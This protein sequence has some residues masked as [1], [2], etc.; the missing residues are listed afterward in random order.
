MPA[1]SSVPL[2]P[3]DKSTC[4]VIFRVPVAQ[5]HHGALVQPGLQTTQTGQVK[6]CQ[7]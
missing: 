5:R 3:R 4:M 1:C 2:P 6:G 7:A